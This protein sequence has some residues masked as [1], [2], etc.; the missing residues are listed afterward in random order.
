MD[1]LGVTL[2]LEDGDLVASAVLLAKVVDEN[3]NVSVGI[4]PSDGCS[5]LEQLGL[6]SAADSLVRQGFERRDDN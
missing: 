4:G 6:V 2:D 1:H 5:W 3:G